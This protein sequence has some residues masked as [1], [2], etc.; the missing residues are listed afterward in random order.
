MVDVNVLYA[1]IVGLACLSLALGLV[2]LIRWLFKKDDAQEKRR[3]NYADI[4]AWCKKV[5]FDRGFLILQNLSVGDY[6]GTVQETAS[7]VSVLS[8]EALAWEALKPNFL[9]QLHERVK[10]AKELA[11]IAAIVE[12]AKSAANPTKQG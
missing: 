4:A 12:A 10:D 6:S 9:Y 8:D 1:V 2:L 11:E 3:K 7:L 5:R